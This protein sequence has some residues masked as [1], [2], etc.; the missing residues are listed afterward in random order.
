[1]SSA[2]LLPRHAEERGDGDPIKYELLEDAAMQSRYAFLMAA[3]SLEA[4]ANALLIGLDLPQTL[5]D[6]LEKLPTLLKF[7]IACMGVG[8]RL[9][10]GHHLYGRIK[11]VIKCRNEFVHPKPRLVPCEVKG[12]SHDVELKISRMALSNYPLALEL[13]DPTHARDAVGDILAFLAWLVFDVCRLG[14]KEG[15]LRLGRGSLR[16]TGDVTNLAQ[17]HGF[18]IRTFGEDPAGKRQNRAVGEF[19]ESESSADT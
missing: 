11:D 10:R 14:I 18:D 7:E 1:M 6:D 2:L 17:E 16:L 5:F 15:A 19:G 3:N 9:D 12:D 13:I 4:A 8:K